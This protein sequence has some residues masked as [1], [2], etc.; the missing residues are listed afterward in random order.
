MAA[1]VLSSLP[2]STK[3][4]SQPSP[5]APNSPSRIGATRPTNG[6]GRVRA[7]EGWRRAYC[8]RC[9]R[10]RKESPSLRPRRRTA[11]QGSARPARRTARVES[12]RLKDGGERIVLAAVVD[13]KNLP[14]FA[15]GAEQPVKDRR[16]PPDER[17]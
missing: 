16:D 5:S 12:V 17:R 13:E 7:P 4:I 11:R 3:R 1:S 8:P 9:R 15:L 6:A 10:R 14:A 2:S